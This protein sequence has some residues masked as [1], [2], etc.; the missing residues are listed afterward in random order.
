LPSILVV[1]LLGYFL[2]TSYKQTEA[3]IESSS[4]NEARIL[5]YQLDSTLRRIE[6]AS[7]T[8]AEN[9]FPAT[10]GARHASLKKGRFDPTLAALSRNFPEVLAYRVFGRDGHLLLSNEHHTL[11]IDISDRAFFKRARQNPSRNLVFSETLNAK[12]TGSPIMVA[13]RSILGSSGEFVGIVVIPVDLRFLARA[14]SEL[15]VGKDGMISVRRSDDSRLVVRWPNV[16]AEINLPATQTPPF[17]LV[18]AGH[19]EGVV[20][21]I[22]KTDRVDRIFAY[23]KVTAYPFY[24]LVGRS[25]T[26]QFRSWWITALVSST[27][28]LSS[29]LLLGG[30][31]LRLK[32]ANSI[33]SER[34]TVLSAIVDHA[35]EAIELTDVET[36][37]FIEFNEASYTLLGYTRE[38]YARLSVVDIQVERTEAQLREQMANVRAGQEVRFETRHRHKD[39]HPIDVQVSIRFIDLHGQ[40]CCVAI[41]GDISERKQAEAQR[42]LAANVFAYAREGIMITAVDGSI[43]TVNDMFSQLTGYERDE[44]Q[45][46]N[47]RFLKSGRQSKDFYAD[48][49]RSLLEHGYW[50]GEIWNRRKSG[51]EFATMQTISSVRNDRGTIQQYVSLFSDITQIKAHEKELEHI[52]HYDTLTGLPNRVLLADRLHQAMAQANRRGQ[53]LAVAYLDLDGFKSINDK[54]GHDVGDQLL[55]KLSGRMKQTLREGDTLSRLG[56]DEFVA[57]LID[58]DDIE[59]SIPMLTRLLASAAEVVQIGELMLQVS[60]SVGVTFFPQSDEVDPDQLLRQADQAMYQA[61]LTGKNRHH[62]FDSDLD[63]SIRGHHESIEH[64]RQ[65]LEA[66]EF[67]L[68]YQPKVNMRT[69]QVIGAEA[70]IRWQHPEQGLLPP[71]MFLPIIEHHPLAI[72]LGEWV[73][74]TA[75][76]QLERWHAQGLVIP[77]S[78]NVGALQLQ[79]ADFVERL[80]ALLAAHPGIKPSCIELEVLET[81]ALQDVVQV[82]EVMES[83]REIGVMFALDDFGTGYSSLTYLKRLP[84]TVLKIDQSFVRDML[85]DPEDLAILE[86]VLGLAT[87]FRRQVIAEGVE[88]VEHGLMLLQLG[89]ELAQGYGIARPMPADDFPGWSAAWCPDAR[90]LSIQAFNS[91]DLPLLYAGVEHRAWIRAVEATL[92]GERGIPPKLDVHLCRLGA[93]LDSTA[94]TGLDSDQKLQSIEGLH[95]QLHGL[96]TELLE[97]RRN[98]RTQEALARLEELLHL[99]D[100]LLEQLKRFTQKESTIARLV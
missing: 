32:R 5:A 45:G 2:Y 86:G 78:V 4:W 68:Y 17:R 48:M 35:G 99:R 10:V 52:A 16:Q 30:L 64:I 13:Y 43:I 15:R 39:G 58:L 94:R 74:N 6:S 82:S 28:T 75:L 92:K 84:A 89:C 80:R 21:Y 69:G 11:N 96:V 59:A 72:E 54:Y 87:A 60:A 24:V 79:Q 85:D 51:E 34:Q 91:D 46:R 3:E 18:Q 25:V 14:F 7:L 67:V 90:W 22:G 93:W 56:G 61:K 76:T 73:I 27:L 8:I 49:W 53:L 98:N 19:T 65:A 47:P 100:A 62:I 40:L 29:L 12:S 9:V 66:S 42:Q 81:S 55:T 44:V 63:R 41:W 70:L 77:V 33:L 95:N 31:M 83:C 50:S 38:E 1:A 23:Q 20:R 88:T 36:L 37:R 57:V 71:A 26:D 97:D